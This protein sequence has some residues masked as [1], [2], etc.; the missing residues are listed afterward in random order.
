LEFG[1]AVYKWRQKFATKRGVGNKG[2]GI[3]AIL[4]QLNI[5]ERTAYHWSSRYEVSKGLK[6]APVNDFPDETDGEPF[7][8]AAQQRRKRSRP[9]EPEDVTP[10]EE[11]GAA[12]FRAS[13]RNA[14]LVL[15]GPVSGE[16][17]RVAR[18]VVDAGNRALAKSRHPDCGG[19]EESMQL[20]NAAV[21]WLRTE[22]A[23]RV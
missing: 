12:R 10:E 6:A 13:F 7:V 4:Q 15:A 20:L 3:T 9:F 14:P 23:G 8:P 16:V 17:L 18:E 22:I 1:E 21:N 19:T 2:K 11:A 5:P